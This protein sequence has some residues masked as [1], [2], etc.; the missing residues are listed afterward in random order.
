MGELKEVIME[1]FSVKQL[2]E[3]LFVKQ[4]STLYPTSEYTYPDNV[5]EQ[6]EKLDGFE[7]WESFSKSWDV[8]WVGLDPRTLKWEIG[9]H[10]S[11]MRKIVGPVRV[12]PLDL[13]TKRMMMTADDRKDI[14]KIEVPFK[15][16]IPET[17]EDRIISESLS[18][19]VVIDESD[20][21]KTARLIKATMEDLKKKLALIEAMK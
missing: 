15:E 9:R 21:D 4:S 14:M 19:K 16:P 5:P 18:G 13:R 6:I 20:K 10:N 12:I 3:R 17:E 8:L 2:R 1:N 11:P 7:T